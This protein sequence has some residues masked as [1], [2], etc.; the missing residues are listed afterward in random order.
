MRI[1]KV[2]NLTFTASPTTTAVVNI[3]FEV[4]GIH[5]KSM[6]YNAG[7]NGTTR[8][9]Y[10]NSDL[11]GNQPMGFI[12]QDTTYSSGTVKD[13]EIIFNKPTYINGTYTFQLYLL[14]GGIAG[15]SNN[16]GAT[17]TCA[18]IAEFNSPDE[19]QSY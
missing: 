14:S 4:K 9:V 8:Y 12:N 10:V 5:V 16:G 1:T 11:T 6:A 7:T 17:D 15:T 3:P 19:D 18:I 2:I 13:I